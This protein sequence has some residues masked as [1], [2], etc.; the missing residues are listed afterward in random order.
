MGFKDELERLR[1]GRSLSPFDEEALSTVAGL[2]VRLKEARSAIE[3]E[4]MIIDDGKGFPIEHPALIIEK[5]ASQEM[6]GWIKERPDLFG[7]Q[8]GSGRRR[9][10]FGSL[11]AVT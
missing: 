3:S 9:S 2:V 6:R 11:K 5:R 8:T 1:D 4:G 7:A 10:T